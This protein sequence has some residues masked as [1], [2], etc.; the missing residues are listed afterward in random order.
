MS[1]IPN[2]P[3]EVSFIKRTSKYAYTVAGVLFLFGIFSA[4]WIY[5]DYQKL[6][7]EEEYSQFFGKQD[8]T[9]SL[10]AMIASTT[11]LLWSFA[12]VILFAF[13]IRQ[14]QHEIELQ[15]K[16]MKDQGETFSEQMKA[17][18]AQSTLLEAQT[19]ATQNLSKQYELQTNSILL[20]Q[21]ENSLNNILNN[22]FNFIQSFEIGEFKSKLTGYLVL[23]KMFGDIS[24]LF[25]DYLE[26]HDR[27]YFKD[28][29]IL[30]LQYEQIF[31]GVYNSNI[32][33]V[34]SN[35]IF[36]HKFIKDSFKDN[37]APYYN[38]LY[39]CYSDAEKYLLG[40]FIINGPNNDKNYISPFD[41]TGFVKKYV[42]Y[43]FQTHYLPI[44]DCRFYFDEVIFK[45]QIYL[46][47]AMVE[48][49][50]YDKTL[51]AIENEAVIAFEIID[52]KNNET[53][54]IQ[55][56]KFTCKYHLDTRSSDERSE[57]ITFKEDE[58][59]FVNNR[60]QI[61]F[62][63]QLRNMLQ[64]FVEGD[65]SISFKKLIITLETELDLH[66]IST[67]KVTPIQVLFKKDLRITHNT[68]DGKDDFHLKYNHDSAY[69]EKY[70]NL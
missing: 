45:R 61:P 17:I 56:L 42:H 7:I 62:M 20:Q 64:M 18:K 38:R 4:F 6:L 32:F 25:K 63:S 27:K 54:K 57:V 2:K 53:I 12:G 13:N 51:K 1:E 33:A 15:I 8:D 40:L 41:F 9:D 60:F 3:K 70:L 43:N 65:K 29:N 30:K 31:Q 68:Y 69:G 46:S 26:S 10:A 59:K 48:A 24:K 52:N 49:V 21:K 67:N 47:D 11:G 28:G 5:N 23:N 22:Y 34:V 58:I 36:I 39:N 37:P 19:K 35:F 66:L 16:E 14:T 44:I 50:E 55:Q